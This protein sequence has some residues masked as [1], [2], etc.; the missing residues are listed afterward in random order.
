MKLKKEEK[1]QEKEGNKILKAAKT[2]AFFIAILLF[3]YFLKCDFK[4]QI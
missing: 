4:F 3:S 2:A 1:F